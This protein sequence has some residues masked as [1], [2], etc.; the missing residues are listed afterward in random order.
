MIKLS[1]SQE[2][3]PKKIIINKDTLCALTIPQV[4]SVNKAFVNLDECNE[5]KDSLFSQIGTYDA[6]VNNQRATI[7]YQDAELEVKNKIIAEKDTIIKSDE[8]KIQEL[9]DENN[10][11]ENKI[12]WLK[13]QRTLYPIL[14]VVVG[15]V[16][17]IIINK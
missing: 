1:I 17:V 15:V 2:G 11:F 13:F 3:Y 4:D 7:K 14:G 10:K 8:N 16:T 12:K 5:L 6:M 9:K